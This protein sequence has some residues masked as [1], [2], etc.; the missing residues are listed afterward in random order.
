MNDLQ[1]H[2]LQLSN[3]RATAQNVREASPME[4][5]AYFLLNADKMTLE[6]IRQLFTD[7]EFS[8]AA[9]VLEKVSKNPQQRQQYEARLKFQ[10]DEAARLES[11]HSE[12]LL[13]GLLEGIEK[14]RVEGEL[15]GQIKLLQSL[16]EVSR[17]T[18]TQL[19][20]YTEVQLSELVDELKRQLRTRKS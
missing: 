4:Q 18:R 17:P 14:G 20:K 16:L 5:W 13:E 9:E 3:L 2:G 11:A 1:M 12:G 19:K 6:E 15:L 10:R 7:I 8:K